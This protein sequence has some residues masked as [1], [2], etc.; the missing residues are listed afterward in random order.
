MST[1]GEILKKKKKKRCVKHSVA[2]LRD[3]VAVPTFT[4][5]FFK[6]FGRT[7]QLS[8]SVPR[9]IDAVLKGKGGPTT[10]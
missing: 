8:A 9:R 1:F 10:Y 7:Y 2:W 5:L 6:M 3:A 4:G